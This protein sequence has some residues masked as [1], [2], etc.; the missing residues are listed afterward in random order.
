MIF[1]CLQGNLEIKRKDQKSTHSPL[2]EYNRE[3]F[4][5]KKWGMKNFSVNPGGRKG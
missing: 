5:F 1:C 2:N 3:K 4:F